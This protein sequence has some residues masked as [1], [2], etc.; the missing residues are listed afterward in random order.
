MLLVI[1]SATAPVL[2]SQP[3]DLMV[4]VP[5]DMQLCSEQ[6][7]S[8]CGN[9]T[10]S[11]PEV[12]YEWFE[13]GRS[14]NFDLCDA[15]NVDESTT[16]TLMVT[17]TNDINLITNGDFANGDDGSFVTD[18]TPG[19]GNCFHG[20]GFLGCEGFYNV[21]T[22]PGVSHNNFASC[23]DIS[24][25]GN[26]MVVNG[27]EFLQ[28]I[29]CQDVCVDP[30]ASYL[31][32]A[33][34]TSVNP[35]SPAQLQFSIDG[36]LIGNIFGLNGTNCSWEQFEEEWQ[37]E[38]Q[39]TVTIC[40]TN[41]N[42][43]AGGND[44][45]LDE[46]EFYQ[47]CREEASFEIKVA[48]LE[49]EIDDP[50]E[51]DCEDNTTN[52][53]LELSSQYEVDDIIWSTD[54][55][56]ILE[57][58]FGGLE[59]VVD[60]G[61]SY[62]V[63][64]F[65]EFG[66]EFNSEVFVESEIVIPEINIMALDT[67][68][69]QTNSIELLAMTNAGDEEFHW[70][71][72][73]G[74]FLGDEE[75]IIVTNGGRYT[76]TVTDD[77]NEC[78]NIASIEISPNITPT[79]LNLVTSNNLDCNNSSTIVS[80]GNPFQSI[81]WSS[82]QSGPLTTTNDS[83]IVTQPG[84]Y[85]AF[86]NQGSCSALDSIV[87]TEIIPNFDYQLSSNMNV[88]T[89]TNP[90]ALATIDLDTALFA[91]QWLDN[92]SNFGNNTSVSIQNPGTFAFI[93][94]DSL[95]CTVRDSI[96]ISED[97]LAPEVEANATAIE[98]NQPSS[99]LSLNI[100]NSVEITAVNWVL[101]N[102]MQVMDDTEIEITEPGTVRYTVT[103]ISTGCSI[104]GAVEVISNEE[105]P[106]VRLERDTLSCSNPFGTL[107]AV[108]S[109]NI[110]SYIWTAPDGTEQ[111]GATITSD[112]AGAH[113]LTATDDK[114]C[115]FS[116][117]VQLA[118]NSAAPVLS[119]IAD[120][121]LT[122]INIDTTL[123]VSVGPDEAVEWSTPAG[124]QTGTELTITEIGSYQLIAT[125]DIGCS[126]TIGFQV[127]KDTELPNLDISADSLDCQ[128]SV[129]TTQ[130][131]NISGPPVS[132][133]LWTF[134]DGSTTDANIID[135][136]EPGAYEALATGTNGCQEI[137]D[138]R[139]G[140]IV[141]EV[142]F[143]L[144]ATPIDCNN[145]ESTI[146]IN[147][148]SSDINQVEYFVANQ[149]I[150]TGNSVVVDSNQEV[151]VVV[152]DRCGE[153]LTDLISPLLDSSK[154]AFSLMAN[155]LGCQV[156]G[157]TL[158]ISSDDIIES[159]SISDENEMLLGDE[160]TLITTSGVYTVNA[161]GQ[162]GCVATEEIEVIEDSATIAFTASTI[163]LDCNRP[164]AE[165]E[166]STSAVY[167]L[168]ALNDASGELV[169]EVSFGE[170]LELTAP[171]SYTLT[172]TNTNGCT[173]QAPLEVQLDNTEVIFDLQATVIDCINNRSDVEIITT[174]SYSSLTVLDLSGDEV[175]SSDNEIS[176]VTLDEP[177]AYSFL[178]E[179]NNGCIS[180][181]LVMIEIDTAT[182]DFSL[183]GGTLECNI[184][185]VNIDLITN[186]N[187]AAG[188]YSSPTQTDIPLAG[189]IIAAEAG[190]YSVELI[191][192]NGCPS[193]Q[194]IEIFQNTDIPDLLL[195]SSETLD[196]NGNGQL[197]D[198]TISG[199]LAPYTINLDN[200]LVTVN[201]IIPIAGTGTHNLSITDDNGCTLDTTFVLEPIEGFSLTT[202]PEF[203][204]IQGSDLQL[205]VESDFPLED[206]TF[207][208][209]PDADLSCSDCPD[210]LFTGTEST[211]YTVTATNAFGCMA[212]AQLRIIV[213]SEVRIYIPNIIDI[214]SD[215]SDDRFTIFTGENDIQQVQEL[216]IYDR[217]GNLLFV[218][219][220]FQPNDPGL[221]WDGRYNEVQVDPG[222]FVYMAV[223]EYSDGTTELF[224]GDVTVLK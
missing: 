195:F 174:D 8:F 184:P 80:T 79:S 49:I 27:A 211:D 5:Q 177:G 200:Q 108:S 86:L 104:S 190:I 30:E 204:I 153:Q 12:A 144:E 125:N 194:T 162:N 97:R 208:W 13:D 136:T 134:P 224:A 44:F 2:P 143:T 58:L 102:G 126:T 7:V 115:V 60:A 94:V 156:S 82:S 133:I 71:D 171:G 193:N 29:W 25:D 70:E 92:A 72:Q 148:G 132:N 69:C 16:F 34:A 183:T 15:T 63:T 210:P 207:S 169:T 3:C 167:D 39:T 120:I 203:N 41:Q 112:Q 129:V 159:I 31:F 165:V 201:S 147:S 77:D 179:N 192:E 47:V 155:P 99:F 116:E 98:C 59:I 198:L 22:D 160:T 118:E 186:D 182:I 36:D 113:R 17:A 35:S 51:L 28:E 106:E 196:C 206:L 187:F 197:T 109:A 223:V 123:G 91:V 158:D 89:C 139:V 213:E 152:T 173:S 189:D 93:V 130:V 66:C 221:G 219:E 61:G 45:A 56:N 214:S 180:T 142:D 54:E 215:S 128:R 178:I 105:I 217:W 26:M 140:E 53:E 199:G 121:T 62:F 222:V 67:L 188:N 124:V 43:S 19:Q 212:S 191:A 100:T 166:L 150:G 117:L 1:A 149:S 50:D 88:L 74:N 65:D 122:C 75:T 163:T 85:I 9:I 175:F 90:A 205:S 216:R 220:K 42:V 135:I 185:S 107:S 11:Y 164:T 87:V 138:L 57:E 141:V 172:V 176:E 119:P 209:T 161:I 46:I 127:L 32:S 33:W 4:T 157:I 218:N 55:G 95:G 73:N 137:F 114:G 37:A 111:M 10:T 76:V 151:T 6:R 84:T 96:I 154:V 168:L 52:I 101:P 110:V 18:Y 24:G 23:D 78:T 131:T 170:P 202:I 83:L 14:A 20:A 145:T 38:G 21:L 181:E 40:V 81:S 103:N 64:I 48:D 68:D 146:S